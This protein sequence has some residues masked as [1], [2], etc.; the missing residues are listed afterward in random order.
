MI[1]PIKK[2]KR[3]IVIVKSIETLKKSREFMINGVPLM[4]KNMMTSNSPVN[5]AWA[6]RG[7]HFDRP[8][9][10]NWFAGQ[11]G[12]ERENKSMEVLFLFPK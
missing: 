12:K 8:N 5:A 10:G 11:I 3:I 9:F 1:A 2:K 4:K 7:F 6:E